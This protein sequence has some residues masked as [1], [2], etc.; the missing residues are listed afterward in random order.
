MNLQII[1]F[2]AIC[3]LVLGVIFMVAYVGH[4]GELALNLENVE[5]K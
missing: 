4:L 5:T 1:K 2:L 3:A